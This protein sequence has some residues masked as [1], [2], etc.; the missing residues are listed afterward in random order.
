MGILFVLIGAFCF[1]LSN[2]YWKKVTQTIPYQVGMFF[3]G[4]FASVVF[5]ILY[6]GFIEGDSKLKSCIEKDGNNKYNRK[7]QLQ[8][9]RK[10]I[11]KT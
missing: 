6:F 4:I 7:G 8:E 10:G 9:E 11:E 3:R 5:A 1:A 2:A